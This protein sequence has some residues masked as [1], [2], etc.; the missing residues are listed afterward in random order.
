MD[1]AEQIRGLKSSKSFEANQ[2]T[3][4]TYI[5][6]HV[7]GRA[8]FLLGDYVAAERLEREALSNRKR[9]GADSLGDKTVLN[10]ISMWIGMALAK[11]GKNDAALREIAPAVKFRR[12]LAARNHGDVFVPYN[13]LDFYMLNRWPTYRAALLK[14]SAVLLDAAPPAVKAMSDTKR[15]RELVREAQTAGGHST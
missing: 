15:W 2:V 7:A 13:W 3:F 10:E 1:A 14:E 12:E 4:G 9:W 11:Q 6:T 8:S 5:V